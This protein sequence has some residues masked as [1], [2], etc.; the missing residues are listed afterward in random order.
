MHQIFHNAPKTPYDFEIKTIP[1]FPTYWGRDGVGGGVGDGGWGG[2][3]LK[4]Q[5]S[6]TSIG[7]HK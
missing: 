5:I 1:N 6:E 4:T 2:G 3:F 7:M